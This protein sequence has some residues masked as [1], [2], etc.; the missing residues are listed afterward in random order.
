MST[1]ETRVDG[2]PEQVR[3]AAEWLDPRLKNAADEA[4]DDTY[5]ARGSTYGHW[6]GDSGPAY[7]SVA[8]DLA[9]AADE[10]R[11]RARDAAEKLR[12][13]A[14][15]LER[16]KEDFASMRGEASAAGLRVV[17]TVIHAP[18]NS[19]GFCPG[20][21]ADQADIDAYDAYADK[22]DVYNEFAT[23]VDERWTLL[24]DWIAGNL[25]GFATGLVDSK[26]K[27]LWEWFST[28]NATA[29]SLH[30]N[31]TEAGWKRHI[32]D[33][34]EAAKETR[35]RAA[36]V[37]SAARSGNPAR[38]AS[39]AGEN[40]RDLRRTARHLDDA[41]EAVR[42]GGRFVPFLGP[43]LDVVM[44]GSDIAGGDSPSSRLVELGAGVA[45]GLLVAGGIAL[46]GV[47][48]PVWG[49][50]LAVTAGAV[51]VGAGGRWLYENVVPQDVRESIDAG[52]GR[53]WD[54]TTD[55]AEDAWGGV[56]GA[57]NSVFG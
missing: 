26:A 42:R 56:S 24:E 48:A 20:P 25:D 3:T 5:R 34:R 1:I 28:V 54:A 16:M 7:R 27:S 12:A 14:G 9:Q 51:A 36:E 57:W 52:L 13:Y 46:A 30:L 43:V 50:A 37:R 6:F 18:V 4:A 19:L 2:E 53:A 38:R 31:A 44:A 45:G 22:V 32:S 55:F 41:A 17:G 21:G 15:Q 39:V 33:L 40:P 47:S 29:V 8:T 23:E 35:A 10:A 49:T 11:G